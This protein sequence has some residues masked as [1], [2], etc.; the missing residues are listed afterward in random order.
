MLYQ[1]NNERNNI[2]NIK[3]DKNRK[4][5]K[6]RS[7]TEKSKQRL[8]N[9]PLFTTALVKFAVRKKNKIITEEKTRMNVKY[10]K[11]TTINISSVKC[12]DFLSIKKQYYGN[13]LR[14]DIATKLSH[15]SMA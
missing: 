8:Q 2:H 4:R 6:Q 12:A 14:M 3:K 15:T 11:F 10:I 9:Q 13:V 5:E 7:N 1:E